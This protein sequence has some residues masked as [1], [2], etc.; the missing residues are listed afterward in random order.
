MT[1]WL[2]DGMN[3]IGARPD[4]WWRDRPAAMR[5]L[6]T[7]LSAFAVEHGDA[8]AVVFDAGP[9]FDHTGIE[10]SFAPRP[11]RDAADDEIARRVGADPDID[12]LRVVTSDR[13]L[14]A[15]VRAHGAVVVGAADFR[16]RLDAFR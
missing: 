2:I 15:R 7:L 5:A 11:G 13:A 9:L 16:R 1:R 14:A 6:A 10:V 8:V 3:V 12:S 4:G